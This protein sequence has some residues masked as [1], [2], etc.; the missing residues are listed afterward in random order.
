MT[1]QCPPT[2]TYPDPSKSHSPE[3]KERCTETVFYKGGGGPRGVN[4]RKLLTHLA[5]A[6][7]VYMCHGCCAGWV[8]CKHLFIN[9]ITQSQT[10]TQKRLNIVLYYT[11]ADEFRTT[12]S[13]YLSVPEGGLW[14]TAFILLLCTTQILLSFLSSVPTGIPPQTAQSVLLKALPSQGVSLPLTRWTA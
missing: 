5:H 12:I 10:S 11:R 7:N 1:E 9:H 4:T 6:Q 3:T 14:Q 13:H 8:L 2:Q